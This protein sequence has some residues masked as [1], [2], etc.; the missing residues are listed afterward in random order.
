MEL[1][2]FKDIVNASPNPEYL[3][4][5]VPFAARLRTIRN[6]VYATDFDFHDAL[7][8]LFNDMKDAHTSYTKPGCYALFSFTNAFSYSFSSIQSNGDQVIILNDPSGIY[9]KQVVSMLD[10]LDAIKAIWQYGVEVGR[11]SMDLSTRFQLALKGY[12]TRALGTYSLPKTAYV[13]LQMAS[14][15]TLRLNWRVTVNRNVTSFT[16]LQRLCLP[17]NTDIRNGSIPYI[18]YLDEG[19]TFK[20]H[21]ERLSHH[22]SALKR[23]VEALHESI[24]V[25]TQHEL[26]N[27]AAPEIIYETNN[28][29]FSMVQPGV[30]AL[31][32]PSFF[33]SEFGLDTIYSIKSIPEFLF[34][35]QR[36][37]VLAYEQNIKEMIIDLRG[38]GGTPS[39]KNSQIFLQAIQG[40]IQ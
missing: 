15:Q 31:K 19:L 34:D 29:I 4:V 36:V 7:S 3:P 16:H 17:V 25:T 11:S 9:D 38:N 40:L 14:G 6:T 23:H 24:P 28:L 5:A 30:G 12:T 2:A 10:G 32:I 39:H 20:T 1:Y 26:S 33:P 21:E 27:Q 18:D 13:T 37:Y 22:Q 8:T 35:M